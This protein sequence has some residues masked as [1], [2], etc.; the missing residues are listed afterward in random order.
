MDSIMDFC[1]SLLTESIESG[2]VRLHGYV[3]TLQLKQWCMCVHVHLKGKGKEKD[4]LVLPTLAGRDCEDR[5]RQ[6][7]KGNMLVSLK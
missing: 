7:K 2:H 6:T 1:F 4:S 5:Q 3:V